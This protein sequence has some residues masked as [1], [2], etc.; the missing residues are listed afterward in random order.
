VS[1]DEILRR[2]GLE[3]IWGVVILKVE[4]HGTV[5]DPA[6]LSAEHDAVVH[7]VTAWNPASTAV[8]AAS[9]IRADAEL[10]AEL[11]QRSVHAERCTGRH[12]DGSWHEEGWAIVGLT[13][14]QACELGRHFKRNRLHY[15]SLED[16][17]KIQT[18][19]AKH[20][21]EYVESRK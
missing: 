2:E 16:Q 12:P 3:E 6:T 15:E 4:R 13:R 19:R 11:V 21:R 7:V 17:L 20:L 18:A 1:R 10:A 5:V 8:D 9:N 14:E